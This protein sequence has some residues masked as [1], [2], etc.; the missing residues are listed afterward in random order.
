MTT[1]SKNDK[2]NEF[3]LYPSDLDAMI[4]ILRQ[5]QEVDKGYIIGSRAMGNY[6][7]GSDVDLVLKGVQL[8]HSTVS[9]ISYLLN[10]ETL[11]PYR[12]D[13]I[14]YNNLQN[15]ELLNHIQSIGNCFT[16]KMKT[17]IDG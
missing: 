11:M 13:V 2:K 9:R 5:H 3:G 4:R 10:E 7:Q 12:F 17:A 14:N 16:R 6:R 15:Q 8:S 1:S